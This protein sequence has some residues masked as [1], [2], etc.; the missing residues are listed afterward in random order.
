MHLLYL[1]IIILLKILAMRIIIYTLYEYSIIY[2]IILNEI[3]RYYLVLI[4]FIKFAIR[5][6]AFIVSRHSNFTLN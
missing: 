5:N 3:M 2:Q 6:Y 4:V 1:S